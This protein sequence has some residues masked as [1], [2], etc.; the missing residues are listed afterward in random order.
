[1]H[2]N[3]VTCAGRELW[4]ALLTDAAPAVELV[5]DFLQ[6]G[7][8]VSLLVAALE[9]RLPAL[10]QTLSSHAHLLLLGDTHKARRSVLHCA[11]AHG[12]VCVVQWA[13]RH[14]SFRATA[15]ERCAAA[16]EAV[17]PFAFSSRSE[18]EQRRVLTMQW[19]NRNVP[20]VFPP[21]V[22]YEAARQGDLCVVAWLHTTSSY[23]SYRAMEFAASRGRLEVAQWLFDHRASA[24]AP[25]DCVDPAQLYLVAPLGAADV[26]NWIAAFPRGRFFREAFATRK[27]LYGSYDQHDADIDWTR[28]E[29]RD[30]AFAGRR[31]SALALAAAEGDLALVQRLHEDKSWPCSPQAMDNAARNGHLEV[32]KWLHVHR[33]EGCTSNAIAGAAGNGHFAVAEWLHAHR[34]EGS[35]AYAMDLAATHGHFEILQW[36]YREFPR[37]ACS[38]PFVACV[39]ANNH[40]TV[41]RWLHS[42]KGLEL[43][44][45]TLEAA[46]ANGHFELAQWLLSEAP[47]LRAQLATSAVAKA[48]RRGHFAMTQWLV[49]D[50]GL[51]SPRALASA[52]LAGNLALVQ[53]LHTLGQPSEHVSSR[54]LLTIG[55]K[56][57]F[58]IISWLL[59]H[60]YAQPKFENSASE[61]KALISSARSL[62]DSK[63]SS[64]TKSTQFAS[65]SHAFAWDVHTK[66]YPSW[67]RKY[68]ELVIAH[69]ASYTNNSDVGPMLAAQRG[70]LRILQTLA[71]GGHP[72][73]YTK[74]TFH[75]V[76]AN[77][78]AGDVFQWL[79]S[80]AP[81]A[82]STLG[83]GRFFDASAIQW[84]ARHKQIGLLE[85]FFSLG[86]R[87]EERFRRLAVSDVVRSASRH[88]HVDLLRWLVAKIDIRSI[89]VSDSATGDDDDDAKARWKTAQWRDA[90]VEAATYGH[91][92][93]LAWIARERPAALAGASHFRVLA[94][95]AMENGQLRALEWVDAA[96]LARTATRLV[97]PS[98]GLARALANKHV[99]VLQLAL[100]R[101]DGLQDASAELRAEIVEF[102]AAESSG[103][104]PM[105]SMTFV[106]P[107]L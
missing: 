19:V 11:A 83:V 27:G 16:A 98:A 7:E 52:A 101:D 45:H 71:A 6:H 106:L 60:G 65:S 86:G 102:L 32:V 21:E 64:N 69:S 99:D 56:S 46:I 96:M 38:Q 87:V 49:C 48:A 33:T 14:R 39:A 29:A 53:W 74:H 89:S 28:A 51:W 40:R 31:F 13:L 107:P 90:S 37:Y 70:D 35:R 84:A 80:T 82:K 61:F 2:V 97:L 43:D 105:G 1:M 79:H 3:S 23:E 104:I 4:R 62:N 75:A 18:R 17:R 85:Y 25:R 34:F 81:G 24:R 47:A 63:A 10:A 58:D 103:F 30:A 22:V 73:V 78:K 88:G 57:G 44:V 54:E 15:G 67:L 8:A 9:A 66:E 76:I 42:E 100:D 36:L 5:A 41:L 59:E 72:E 94:E 92:N 93:V 77:T 91:A 95:A 20:Y 68:A 26:M 12:C 55:A 50:L